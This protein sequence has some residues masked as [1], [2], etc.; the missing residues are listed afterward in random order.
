MNIASI[1]LLVLF[2]YS[3]LKVVVRNFVRVNYGLLF[4]ILFRFFIYSKGLSSGDKS[5][6]ETSGVDEEYD[7]EDYDTEDHQ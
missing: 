4:P 1:F 7:G 2:Q 6:E 3:V 5:D